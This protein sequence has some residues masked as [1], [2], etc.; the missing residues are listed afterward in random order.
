VYALIRIVYLAVQKVRQKEE[1]LDPPPMSAW[2]WVAAA[3]LAIPLRG[4]TSSAFSLAY[5]F[6]VIG[7]AHQVDNFLLFLWLAW[8]TWFLYRRGRQGL[9]LYPF[10]YE[11]GILLAASALFSITSRWF[12]IPI[13]FLLGWS[14][15]KYIIRPQQEWREE[16]EPLYDQVVNKRNELLEEIIN[17]NAAERAH[18]DY[19][20]KLGEK[21]VN[22]ETTVGEFDRGLK[23]RRAQLD[24]LQESARIGNLSYKEVALVFG[25]F[26]TAWRNAVH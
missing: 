7:L 16:L 3:F 21:L 18:W 8:G 23:Q 24:R 13:T 14:L 1:K 12:Y 15:L 20:K 10:T 19:R 17:V 9:E 5:Q 11:I 2:V 4:L 26:P 6:D 25:P 22:N